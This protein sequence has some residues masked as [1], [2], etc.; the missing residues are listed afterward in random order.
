M[1]KLLQIKDILKNFEKFRKENIREGA[2]K[3]FT[4][5]NE[6]FRHGVIK[7]KNILKAILWQI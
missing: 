1:G 7:E 2:D 3:F 5:L 4:L 6:I